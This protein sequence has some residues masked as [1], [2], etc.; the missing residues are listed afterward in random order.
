MNNKA[1]PQVAVLDT[2]FLIRLLKKDDPLHQSA[3]DF[4]QYLLSHEFILYVSTVALAEYCVKGALDEIPFD[5]L[6]VIPFNIDHSPIA[7]KY[8][9]SLF[10]ARAKGS[11]KPEHRLVI[12]NDTKI[13]AQAAKLKAVYIVTADSKSSSA[14]DVLTNLNQFSVKLL[15]IHQSIQESF[16]TFF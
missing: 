16:G 7:G 3:L 15:D 11:Y 1:N 2:S 5:N 14:V 13:F 8:A 6:R 9:A 12:P 4:F 10:E